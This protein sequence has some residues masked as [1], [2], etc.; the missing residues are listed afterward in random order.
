MS[1]VTRSSVAAAFALVVAVSARADVV[2]NEIMYNSIE[3][4]D[5]EYIELYNSGPVAVDLTNW[6]LLDADP[7]HNRCYLVG[8]LQPGAYLVV[9]GFLSTFQAKYPGVTNVNPN[10]FDSATVGAGWAL[11]NGGDN[12]RLFDPVGV[13]MDFV[14]YDDVPPW[15]TAAAGTGPSLELIFPGLDNSLPS[16]WSASVNAP[17]E[18]TPG[19]QNSVYTPDQAPIVD[20]IARSAPL[21]S[22]FDT[23]IVTAR[24]TDDHAVTAVDLFVNTGGGYV[25]QT[26][27]DDG[28][29][30]DGPAGNQI[31]GAVIT[32]KPDG[33]IVKY[34][35]AARDTIVQTTTF[36]EGAPTNYVGYT[37]GY[38]PPPIFVN[39]ILASNLTGIVDELGQVE[40]W[41]ELRNRDV[42][43]VDLGGMFLSDNLDKSQVWKIPS[44][45]IVPAGGRV[46]FWCDNDQA[47]GPLHTSFKLPKAAGR[48]GIFDSVDHGNTMIHGFYYGLQNTDVSFGFFPDDADAP[49]YM[50][51][52]TPG[53]SNDTS[54]HFSAVCI[55]EFQTTSSAGGI[56][57][58]IE[59]YNRTAGSVVIGGWHLTD[60]V[61]LP[62]KYTF[63]PG[64]TLGGN[65]RIVRSEA[66]LGFSLSSTGSE[67]IH[68]V[69]ADGLTGLDF[70]DYGPQTM[71]LSQGRYPEG[72]GYWH[73][74]SPNSLGAPN[75]CAGGGALPPV[76]NLRFTAKDAIAWDVLSGAQDY[77]VQRGDLTV[78]RSSSGDFT[79]SILGCAEND[80]TDT[81]SYVPESPGSSRFYLVRGATF[82]CGKGTFD[83]GSP[84]QIGTR[85]AEIAAGAA[86]P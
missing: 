39:E 3:P 40:D 76:S 28:L 38:R 71:D 24:A 72:S 1:P 9:A 79:A 35:V 2:I 14:N 60:D 10:P 33:T 47:Q 41:V 25:S 20:T 48:I 12:V 49:D 84:N 34:Y 45:T 61:T 31:Y 21:P 57:D 59:L 85:D 50:T 77:D 66:E 42:V 15:P 8:T 52:P 75:T 82:A 36:P 27:F 73:F 30:G 44:P 74:F 53:S 86:C 64:T 11:G 83:E 16:S 43:S 80:G 32:P 7:L 67:V 26:M 58:Y 81:R 62:T 4:T 18:G 51:T 23:V 19:A 55:N 29:H 68:L 22:D 6:N 56:D 63:L 78:L 65:S 5:V 70:F 54:S 37:V 46:V 17:A 69:A 13:L